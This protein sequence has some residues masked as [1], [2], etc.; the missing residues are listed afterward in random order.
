MLKNIRITVILMVLLSALSAC[1]KEKSSTEE[2]PLIGEWRLVLEDYKTDY[3]NDTYS[4]KQ[5][6]LKMRI[7]SA[8]RFSRYELVRQP[9]LSVRDWFDGNYTLSNGTI[10]FVYDNVNERGSKPEVY[11]IEQPDANKL[12]F[13]KQG[14]SSY[15]NPLKITYTYTR[16]R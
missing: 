6:E 16:D 12:I 2:N 8:T 3:A 15:G 13:S 7:F 1:K 4:L 10:S 5:S 11:N 9:A 14:T